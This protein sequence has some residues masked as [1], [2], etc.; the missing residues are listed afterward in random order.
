MIESLLECESECVFDKEPSVQE[1]KYVEID[2]PSDEEPEPEP[3]NEVAR[4]HSTTINER[5]A[6]T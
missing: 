2:F 5:E 4:T 1:R 6:S 3:I